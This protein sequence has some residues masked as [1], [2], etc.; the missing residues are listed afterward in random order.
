MRLLSRF[1]HIIFSIV[2][3]SYSAMSTI[4]WIFLE[5]TPLAIPFDILNINSLLLSPWIS[6]LCFS[7]GTFNLIRTLIGILRDLRNSY[8]RRR[9]LKK[10]AY[11]LNLP[12]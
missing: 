4:I 7:L 8:I 3:I 1:G 12:R 5:L 2:L 11:A 10:A 6:L 9:K